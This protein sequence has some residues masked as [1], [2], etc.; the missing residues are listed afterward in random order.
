MKRKRLKKFVTILMA[1]VFV[2]SLAVNANAATGNISAG[3][4]GELKAVNAISILG[5]FEKRVNISVET[6]KSAAEKYILKY[7]V[8]Y[9]N[10]GTSITGNVQLENVN[11]Y[12]PMRSSESV[13]MHHWKNTQTGQYDG[14]IGTKIKAYTTHEVRG[15]YA[16]AIY[17]S[18][19]A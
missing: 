16:Y 19:T 6:T 4:Y 11:M 18:E 14:F 15:T 8:V 17:L 1:M 9:A 10:T 5:T 7:N 12:T 2:V 13:E 3:E